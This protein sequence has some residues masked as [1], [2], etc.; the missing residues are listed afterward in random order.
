MEGGSDEPQLQDERAEVVE[1]NLRQNAYDYLEESLRYAERAVADS[2]GWKFAI[3]LAAQSIELLLKA[4]LAEEHPLLIRV[5]PESGDTDAP[6]VGVESAV[7]R[8][9]AAGLQLD[10]E[11][12]RRL[13]LAQ[14]L[15]NQFVHYEVKA[16]VGQLE[17]TFADLFEFAHVFHLEHLGDELH[18]HIAEDL[19]SAEA[20]MM[21]RFRRDLVRYQGSTV[22]RWFPS[23]IVDA[24]FALNVRIGD[25]VY[26]RIRRSSPDDLLGANTWACHDCSAV[27]GQLHAYGCDAERCPGCSQQMLSCACEWEWEYVESIDRFIP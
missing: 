17:A 8:L 6:T 22:V 13:R 12:V 19:Y 24:Q 21:S 10:D 9:H 20:E 14:R 3:V 4:R 2:V 18:D 1:L 7:K 26:D 25:K 23:E 11:D 27:P 5:N 16:T 15:R